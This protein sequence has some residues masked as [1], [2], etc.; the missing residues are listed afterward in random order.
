MAKGDHIYVRRAL[1][2]TFFGHFTAVYTQG[3]RNG[4]SEDSNFH[5]EVYR[6][7]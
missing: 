2:Y 7:M 5:A 4:G 1:G 3:G 6:R